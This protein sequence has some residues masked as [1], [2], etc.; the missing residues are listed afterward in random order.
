[1]KGKAGLPFVVCFFVVIWIVV[2]QLM[3]HELITDEPSVNNLIV[4][5]CIIGGIGV[6]LMLVIFVQYFIERS[7]ARKYVLKNKRVV[8]TRFTE[9]EMLAKSLNV[10]KK[11]RD[12]FERLRGRFLSTEQL[13]VASKRVDWADVREALEKI[14][15]DLTEVIADIHGDAPAIRE[16]G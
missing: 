11:I 1:M 10:D 8:A 7:S 5:M 3:A 4:F 14:D 12:R 6:F 16:T 9:V 13:S 2:H 15:S